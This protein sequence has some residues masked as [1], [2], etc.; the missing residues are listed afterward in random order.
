MKKFFKYIS[1]IVLGIITAF[2]GL[3]TWC[4]LYP[5]ESYHHC[6]SGQEEL[7]G[8]QCILITTVLLI[9]FCFVWYKTRKW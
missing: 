8:Q 5:D 6:E 4:A 3:I 2:M 9:L 1:R 7:S